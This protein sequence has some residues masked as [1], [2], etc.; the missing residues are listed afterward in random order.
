MKKKCFFGVVL[1]SVFVFS[2]KDRAVTSAESVSMQAETEA[3]PASIQPDT[4]SNLM[5][6]TAAEVDKNSKRKFVKTVETKFKVKD[7][8]KSTYF[9]ESLVAKNGGYVTKSDLVSNVCSSNDIKVNADTTLIISKFIVENNLEFKIPNVKLDTLLRAISKEVAYL[10]YRK[11]S[12]EDVTLTYLQH[13]LS[14]KTASK[15]QKRVE[16]TIATR[17]GKVNQFIEGENELTASEENSNSSIINHLNLD[18][19]TVIIHLYQNS[20]LKKDIEVAVNEEKYAPSFFYRLGEGLKFGWHLIK[21]IVIGFSSI[22]SI[23]LVLLI[24]FYFVKKRKK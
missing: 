12:N 15:H 11:I 2:C 23:L 4:T 16:K 22:W 13:K 8:A 20:S 6:S 9:I 19:S 1:F 7:V 24:L 21:E 14:S 3:A 18:F 17:Q 10:E 5:T